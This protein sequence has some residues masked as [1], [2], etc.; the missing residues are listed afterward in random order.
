MNRVPVEPADAGGP[1]GTGGAARAGGADGTGG[2]AGPGPAD[3]GDPAALAQ[4]RAALGAVADP[5]LH[6]PITELGMVRSVDVAGGTVR[7]ELAL[8]VAGCPLKE[9]FRREV[10]AA[11]RA[12]L[13]WVTEVDVVLGTMDA[14]QRDRAVGSV[15]AQ[16]PRIGQPGSRTRVLAVGSGKGGVGKSTIAVNLAAALAASGHATGLLDAD[17]YGFS[18]PALTGAT[19][20]ATV[21]GDLIMPIE[22]HGVKVLSIGNFVPADSAIV[23]RG[24]MLHK[25]LTQLL[26][27]VHWEDCEFLVV[28]LPPGTGDVAISISQLLPEAAFLAVTGPDRAAA[29]VAARAARMALKVGLRLLGAVENFAGLAC[30]GCGRHHDVFGSGGGDLLAAECDIGLLARV[31]LDPALE[32]AASAGV[33]VVLGDPASPAA[34][35]LR[36]LA[37]YLARALPAP[38][39]AGRRLLPV[40]AVS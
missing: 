12:R 36:D 28:D 30:T 29:V 4:V 3:V 11:L 15:R 9:Y 35:V 6:R 34:A 25:T 27:D 17:V 13:P 19:A 10:P 23:W 37:G 21:V 38:A 1:A 31:P 20:R 40:V 39:E 24:P 8:T 32:R 5:E 7:V 2:A 22:A 18:I 14:D 33:P 16:T 26:V